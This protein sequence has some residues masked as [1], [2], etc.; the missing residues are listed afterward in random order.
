MRRSTACGL[1][2][3][4]V[5][6]SV[7]VELMFHTGTGTLSALGY[8]SVTAL[9][10]VGALELMVS[11]K[12]LL[13]RPVVLLGI[14]VLATLLF[15]KVFCAWLCPTRCIDRF[16]H[17]KDR[18]GAT[19]ATTRP[20]VSIPLGKAFRTCDKDSSCTCGAVG[21]DPGPL[22][23]VGGSRDGVR[24]DSR[25][26]VLL[27]ALLS[28]GIFGFPVFCLIC[29]VG[30]TFATFIGL[31]HLVQ[32]GEGTWGLLVFPAI[33]IVEVVGFRKWCHAACPIG[34]LLSLVSAGNRTLRPIVDGG[35]C[36]RERG[37]DCH[38]CVDICPEQV[39]PH[40][41]VIPECTKCGL[42]TDICPTGAIGLPLYA[43]MP[44][45]ASFPKMRRN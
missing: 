33:V 25:H 19:K 40:S 35:K 37:I 23:K 32:Y 24:V 11:A 4:A 12:A 9:C 26:F 13:L 36:L 5:F 29:P 14:M 45:H 44:K 8:G 34:A 42:C 1:V 17:P 30:L 31:W 21:V 22:A 38:A 16:F 15:G 43:G 6:G 3:G 7:V 27:G 2:Q 20:I 18:S 28:S 39:D 41:E 10:P